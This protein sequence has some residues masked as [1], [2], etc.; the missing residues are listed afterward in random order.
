MAAEAP[1][2]HREIPAGHKLY[3][4]SEAPG[5][6][7]RYKKRAWFGQEKETAGAYAEEAKKSGLHRDTWSYKTQ[8]P[9][10]LLDLGN[11]E[12]VRRL[13]KMDAQTQSA[14]MLRDLEQ[15]QHG[16]KPVLRKSYYG[17]D[18]VLVDAAVKLGYDGYYAPHFENLL[19]EI[20]LA[21]PERHVKAHKNKGDEPR[22]R[23][24]DREEVHRRER[25]KEDAAALLDTLKS[26]SKTMKREGAMWYTRSRGKVVEWLRAA[27][28][29]PAA[30]P[31]AQKWVA[32]WTKE[33]RDHF[34]SQWDK[35]VAAFLDSFN[36]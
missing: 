13:H 30:H 6:D 25:L 28:A 10:R 12:A 15:V 23:F 20:A 29:D 18:D 32:S 31:D 33:E 4:S 8:R 21:D 11:P 5:F 2:V 9:L 14:L 24:I 22:K 16:A 17:G 26:P 27:A 19:E 35:P 1:A 36:K 34:R 3:R 7:G